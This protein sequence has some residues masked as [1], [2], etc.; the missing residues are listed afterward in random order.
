MN[1]KSI[2]MALFVMVGV[3]FGD[4]MG[5]RSASAPKP[6]C[7]PLI[8]VTFKNNS[9]STVWIMINDDVIRLIPIGANIN[10]LY[11]YSASANANVS[12]ISVYASTKLE[13]IKKDP[14]AVYNFDTPVTSSSNEGQYALTFDGST[15]INQVFTPYEQSKEQPVKFV[16]NSKN[17]FTINYNNNNQTLQGND[18][19]NAS[20]TVKL[21][22][23]QTCRG[24]TISTTYKKLLSKT[25]KFTDF[26]ET[27]TFSIDLKGG[28]IHVY[29]DTQQK[30]EIIPQS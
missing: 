28:D 8:S 6:N 5:G 12:K 4:M 13:D 11:L 10:Y 3:S 7:Q 17:T 25:Y 22:I 1:K 14:V 9:S 2:M 26:N 23:K 20:D 29:N 19:Q 27:D 21:P 18:T 15:T 30:K 24:F 16:I